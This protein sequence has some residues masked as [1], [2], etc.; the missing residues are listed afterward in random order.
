VLVARGSYH[1]AAPWCT[2]SLAGVTAEDRA[3]LIHFE[4][5][6]VESLNAAAESAGE[7]LAAVIVTP[8]RQ[9]LRRNQELATPDFAR[10]V[11]SICDGSGAALILDDVRC[12]FRID[13][14]GSWEPLGVR[15]DLS[16]YSKA[17]ANGMPL[18]A[19]AGG[20]R[21][22][23]AATQVYSTGSFW[24]AAGAMAASLATLRIMKRD[25]VIAHMEAAGRK[26]RNGM[27]QVAERHG[28]GLQQTGPVQMP[29]ML[30]EDDRDFSLGEAFCSAAIRN[31]LHLHP[32]HN[33]FL[34]GAHGRDEIDEALERAERAFAELA[35][36]GR[37]KTAMEPG[38]GKSATA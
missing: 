14:A 22:R 16:A 36:A 15:P 37:G 30:F 6:D 26:F 8:V 12:G 7:D 27:Q 4:Y 2:P 11:R 32:W 10:R 17:I 9:N 35:A 5:N 19:A 21:F 31:G 34:S 18:A 20:D 38:T 1:G 25:G 24:C 33:M 13:L 3:H 23:E 29:M 28:I